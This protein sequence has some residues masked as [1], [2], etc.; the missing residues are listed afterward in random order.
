[1]L[2]VALVLLQGEVVGA[3]DHAAQVDDADIVAVA[4]AVGP[5]SQGGAEVDIGGNR[6][7]AVLR[8]WL[9]FEN[10]VHSWEPP[11]T[12]MFATLTVL[13]PESWVVASMPVAPSLRMAPASEVKF[14]PPAGSWKSMPLTERVPV[15]S[16]AAGRWPRW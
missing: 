6:E 13:S 4:V 10:K 7:G 9:V 5:D 16:G 14:K 1:M 12:R 11:S 2:R 3:A 8:S 15:R